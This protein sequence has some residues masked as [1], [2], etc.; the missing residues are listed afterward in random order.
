MENIV[1]K[2]NLSIELINKRKTLQEK[3]QELSQYNNYLNTKQMNYYTFK[4]ENSMPAITFFHVL[5]FI[6]ML[7]FMMNTVVSIFVQVY[8]NWVFQQNLNTLKRYSNSGMIGGISNMSYQVDYSG[9]FLFSILT[10]VAFVVC[11]VTT[12]MKK[13]RYA[14]Y[15]QQ[16]NQYRSMC[17]S[18]VGEY[19][20]AVEELNSF[21]AYMSNPQICVIPKDYWDNALEI[22]GYIRNGV[23]KT[24]EEAI[25]LL[26][27]KKTETNNIVFCQYCG[28]QNIGAG[29]FC[30]KCGQKLI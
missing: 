27:P 10:V 5:S 21:E 15:L 26:P 22:S 6:A 29:G 25:R 1:E 18:K 2:L 17:Q 30:V 7:L 9:I 14:Q 12:N 8:N 19:Q 23:A 4:Y 11:I 16:D 28:T 20:K 13:K 3:V 24:V